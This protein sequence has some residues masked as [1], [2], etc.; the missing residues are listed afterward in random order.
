LSLSEKYEICQKSFRFARKSRNS[1][2][3]WQPKQDNRRKLGM[4]KCKRPRL[5]W[6]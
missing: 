6:L 5:C 4:L 1:R 2:S 3:D